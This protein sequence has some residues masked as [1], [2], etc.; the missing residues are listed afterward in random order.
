MYLQIPSGELFKDFSTDLVPILAAK[1]QELSY[2]QVTLTA[3]AGA[4]GATVT[5][6]VFTAPCK[7][8]I[9]RVI[10]TVDVVPT[11]ADN[12]PT[13]ALY[14]GSDKVGESSA[15]ALTAAIGDNKEFTL[16]SDHVE[17]AKGDKLTFKIVNPTATITTAAQAHLQIEWHA[18]A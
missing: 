13:L 8:K 2:N 6:Y 10:G 9:T 5:K 18:I 15:I 12:T 1:L 14:N 11:G 17:V 3:T 16:D 4:S 7:M